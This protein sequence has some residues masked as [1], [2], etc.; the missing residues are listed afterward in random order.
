MRRAHITAWMHAKLYGYTLC[1]A[2]NQAWCRRQWNDA[3]HIRASCCS[4][5]PTQHQASL[6]DR[7]LSGYRHC[8]PEPMPISTSSTGKHTK[9][10]ICL[11]HALPG[12]PG[13]SWH[14]SVCNPQRSAH[15]TP[16]LTAPSTAGTSPLHH[17]CYQPAR[18]Q[19][20]HCMMQMLDELSQP[21]MFT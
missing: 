8:C 17:P 7:I 21:F 6:D 1:A 18:Q 2:K 20:N 11:F 5:V 16:D 9:Q 14:W 10:R 4:A 19:H 15:Q 12:A 3:F 13:C